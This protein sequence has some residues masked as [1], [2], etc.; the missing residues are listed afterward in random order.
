MDEN[1]NEPGQICLL[2][3]QLESCL[4]KNLD[5]AIEVDHLCLLKI[6]IL[7]VVKLLFVLH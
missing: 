2:M 7:K 6:I 5:D 4:D 1:H 3:S